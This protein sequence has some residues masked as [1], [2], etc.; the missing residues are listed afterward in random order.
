MKVHL[1]LQAAASFLYK[2]LVTFLTYS[3]A[4]FHT[5]MCG[6]LLDTAVKIKMLNFVLYKYYKGTRLSEDNKGV[7]AGL[8]D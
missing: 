2:I 6:D 5:M 8:D 7:C 1:N 4:K 3:H